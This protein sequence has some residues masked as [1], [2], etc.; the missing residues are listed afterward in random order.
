MNFDHRAPISEVDIYFDFGGNL[1][2]RFAD[3]GEGAAEQLSSRKLQWDE[4]NSEVILFDFYKNSF[5]RYGVRKEK[6]P[7]LD[8]VSSTM[9]TVVRMKSPIFLPSGEIVDFNTEIG[10]GKLINKFDTDREMI[11]Y[12]IEYPKLDYPMEDF[13]YPEA[14]SGYINYFPTNGKILV[15]L[16][17]VDRLYLLD[18]DLN[19]LATNIGPDNFLPAFQ[20]KD[21]VG[22]GK[23]DSHDFECPRF[24]FLSMSMA[25]ENTYLV[26]YHGG[27]ASEAE[28]NG[29]IIRFDENLVPI[30][31]YNLDTPISRFAFSQRDSRIYAFLNDSEG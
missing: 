18:E 11:A 21:V 31:V 27:M 24:G 26:S 28:Q 4:E 12:A 25:Y 7:P 14:F 2:D 10:G 23:L 30:A 22:G 16:F 19:L 3:E 20:G 6:M 13:L 15:N 8:L 9:V 29:K 17:F 1:V 5:F